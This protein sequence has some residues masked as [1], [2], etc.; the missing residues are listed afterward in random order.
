MFEKHERR[1]EILKLLQGK[2]M[3]ISE[4][5]AYFEVDERTIRSDIN[6]L[7]DGLDIFGV[8]IR[9]ES[10]HY[11]EGNPRHRYKSTV[12]PIMLA[13]NSSELFALL[14][15]LENAKM[16][17]TGEVYGHIFDMVYSQITDYAEKL[18]AD[19][20]A[21]KHSKSEVISRLE[22]QAFD[23]SEDYKLVYWQKS[24]RV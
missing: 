23:A 16:Q 4:I 9:I 22:E 17:I 3:R 10:R 24:G 13:L 11:Y 18:F 20:L 19:K 6:A 15:L 5:A 8:K 1:I 12:H 7:R 21:N 14:K 2:E